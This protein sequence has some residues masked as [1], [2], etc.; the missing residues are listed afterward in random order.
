MVANNQHNEAYCLMKYRCEKCNKIEIIW[1]SR[2]GVTPFCIKCRYCEEG[3]STHINWGKDFPQVSMR[4]FVDL[5]LE[6]KRELSEKKVEA[7]WDHPEYPMKEA[8]PN[9]ATAILEI[10]KGFH[11]GE[12]DVKEI[13]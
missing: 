6:R 3:M 1:N 7:Y 5:T 13:L 12:P 9:K 10:M 2:D 8:F 11:D 4:M